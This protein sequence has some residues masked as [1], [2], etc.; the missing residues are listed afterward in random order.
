MEKN[1][2]MNTVVSNTLIEINMICD[3]NNRNRIGCS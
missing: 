1:W 3:Q 2:I